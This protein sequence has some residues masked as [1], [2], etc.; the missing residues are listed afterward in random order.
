MRSAR[1]MVLGSQPMPPSENTNCR[2]GNLRHT[3]LIMRLTDDIIEPTCRSEKPRTAGASGMGVGSGVTPLVPMCRHSTIPVS[4]QARQTGSQCSFQYDGSPRGTLFSGNDSALAPLAA[5]RRISA[6][7]TSGSH[8]WEMIVGEQAGRSRRAPLVDHEVVV[9]LYRQPGEHLVAEAEEKG[10]CEAG[11]R[12]EEHAAQDPVGQHVSG[13][14]SGLVAPRVHVGEP[15]GIGIEWS[16]GL[17]TAAFSPMVVAFV[18]SYTQTS[19]SPS[20]STCGPESWCRAGRRSV[21]TRACSMMWSSALNN[22]S[23]W[24]PR[25]WL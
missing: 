8:S 19:W 18:P 25:I 12:R 6:A 4:S 3:G 21:Q 13:P 11:K 7:A 9:G 14:L 23:I 15:D 24:P 5:H 22:R 2:S 1:S 17:P 20:S 16:F 10:P